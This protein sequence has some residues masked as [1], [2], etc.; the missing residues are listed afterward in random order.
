MSDPKN[1]DAP[2]PEEPTV[3]TPD[4]P[5]VPSEPEP[6]FPSPTEPTVPAFRVAPI[7]GACDH[8]VG[9]GSIAGA[10][11]EEVFVLSP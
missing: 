4:E 5:T 7:G 9:S 1:P 8:F 11:Y 6:T 10:H 3:P 2:G